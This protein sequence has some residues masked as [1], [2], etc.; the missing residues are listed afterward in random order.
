[1]TEPQ[2]WFLH[3]VQATAYG[4]ASREIAFDTEAHCREAAAAVNTAPC[5]PSIT[6]QGDL[7][8][9]AQAERLSAFCALPEPAG[10]S[11]GLALVLLALL[12]RR[13]P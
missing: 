9:Y 6:L 10:A 12:S 11:L 8:H 4:P 2:Q 7:N 13:R 1:M 5:A 3:L